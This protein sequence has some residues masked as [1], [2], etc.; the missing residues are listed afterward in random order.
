MRA[1]LL[2]Y[3]KCLTEGPVSRPE[4][5]KPN[6]KKKRRLPLFFNIPDERDPA[7]EFKRGSLSPLIS[8]MGSPMG[9][10]IRQKKAH[11]FRRAVTLYDR[12]MQAGCRVDTKVWML[13]SPS[14]FGYD[15]LRTP[16]YFS[17]QRFSTTKKNRESVVPSYLYNEDSDSLGVDY[18]V[19]A[20]SSVL[21]GAGFSV[22]NAPEENEPEDMML[23]EIPDFADFIASDVDFSGKS[24]RRVRIGKDLVREGSPDPLLFKGFHRVLEIAAKDFESLD[25]TRDIR[26]ST[27]LGYINLLVMAAPTL[28][29]DPDIPFVLRQEQ[30]DNATLI[31]LFNTLVAGFALAIEHTDPEQRMQ[32]KFHTRT[33]FGV[34]H[35]PRV[36]YVLHALAAE[37]L[38]IQVILYGLSEQ[39]GQA[40]S[41]LWSTVRQELNNKTLSDCISHIGAFLLQA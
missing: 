16:A 34:D 24:L 27:V 30:H 41:R 28:K 14:L 3:A 40:M 32:I 4:S 8:G 23:A 26:E 19:D 6:E 18:W 1:L 15:F 29:S 11:V 21:G 22:G 13:K 39:Q 25:P 35:D 38:N 10:I 7:V 2:W 37:W 12:H 20:C 31:D 9:P 5:T 33:P 17:S 36:V